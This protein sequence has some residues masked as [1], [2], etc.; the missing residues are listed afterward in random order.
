MDR[1]PTFIDAP[2]P[3]A[4]SDDDYPGTSK[5]I[6]V[7]FSIF[8]PFLS[9]IVALVLRG[10]ERNPVRRASLKS[11]AW[12]S[13]ALIALGIVIAIA[14]V[15]AFASHTSSAGGTNSNGPCQGGPRMGAPGEQVGP[16][17]YR[18]PCEFG[19]STIVRF[20]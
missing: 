11:W 13:G 4:P 19:G 15:A 10:S 3:P 20:P 2:A 18:F 6:A 7:L 1:T 5:A 8:A 14:L 16:H 17:K 12:L 9:L